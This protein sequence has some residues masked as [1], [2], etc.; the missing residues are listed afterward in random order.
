M[1]K[2][3]IVLSIIL[4]SG[5]ASAQVGGVL[6]GAAVGGA[7]LGGIANVIMSGNANKKISKQKEQTGCYVNGKKVAGWEGTITLDKIN[8]DSQKST[9]LYKS[10][11]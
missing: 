9:Q 8:V 11:N 7:A 5:T 2:L 4:I 10:S 6:G 3:I 1:K